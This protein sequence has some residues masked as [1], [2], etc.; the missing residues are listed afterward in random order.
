LTRTDFIAKITNYVKR[1]K[2]KET[3]TTAITAIVSENA[4]QQHNL[5]HKIP[6]KVKEDN[7]IR[8]NGRFFS[9]IC[10]GCKN[11]IDVFNFDCYPWVTCIKM[12]DISNLR[13]VCLVCFKVL[14]LKHH[15]ISEFISKTSSSEKT[16]DSEKNDAI[17]KSDAIDKNDDS[18]KSDTMNSDI[19][20][21][22]K[23]KILQNKAH[24]QISLYIY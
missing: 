3:T 4:L 23:R 12:N 15:D 2:S 24:F 16:N 6:K 7:W 21:R 17:E 14:R 20:I 8:F 1:T 11:D 19:E 18:D 5:Y 13:P 9:G 22:Q 10:F